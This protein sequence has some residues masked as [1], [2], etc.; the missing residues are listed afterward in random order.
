MSSLVHDLISAFVG[1]LFPHLGITF[2]PVGIGDVLYPVLIFF[3]FFSF[4]DFFASDF[5][6]LVG[7]FRPGGG[8]GAFGMIL[9]NDF[10]C[11]HAWS[12]DWLEQYRS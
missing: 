11:D 7:F 4:A 5:C 8:F 3:D 2:D 12:K 1:G 6:F 9:P 10:S